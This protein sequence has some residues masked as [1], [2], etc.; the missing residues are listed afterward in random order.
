MASRKTLE[1]IEKAKR[2]S[3]V[4][5]IPLFGATTR[6]KLSAILKKQGVV[7]SR[8]IISRG[9]VTVR[10]GETR[11]GFAANLVVTKRQK[12]ILKK[13]GIKPTLK[14]FATSRFPR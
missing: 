3:S 8:I 7:R 5:I 1:T 4:Q 9:P 2:S 12:T 14:A 6:K 11:P 13:R 10:R